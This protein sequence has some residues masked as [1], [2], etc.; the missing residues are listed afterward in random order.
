MISDA[1]LQMV[2]VHAAYGRSMMA[3]HRLEQRLLAIVSC[4]PEKLPEK[5]TAEKNWK[6]DIRLIS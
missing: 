2:F 4:Y 5:Y 3:A 1:S 6:N